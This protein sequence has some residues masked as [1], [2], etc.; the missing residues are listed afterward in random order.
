MNDVLNILHMYAYSIFYINP[1]TRTWAFM[2][3]KD[4]WICFP[5]F[6]LKDVCQVHGL[7]KHSYCDLVKSTY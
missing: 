2:H 3:F 1:W 4:R 6:I 5:S 7:H